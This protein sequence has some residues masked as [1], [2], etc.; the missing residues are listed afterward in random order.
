MGDGLRKIT[1]GQGNIKPCGHL[2]RL[3]FYSEY[4]ED[5][6]RDWSREGFNFLLRDL[7]SSLRDSSVPM[8]RMGSQNK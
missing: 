6:C 2:Q 1:R 8:L 5:H 4:D 3:G 7:T